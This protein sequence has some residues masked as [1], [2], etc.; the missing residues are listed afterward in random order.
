MI[1]LIDIAAPALLVGLLIAIVHVP[2][3]V[4]VIKR[5][6]IFI[7]LAIAQIAALGFLSAEIILEDAHPFIHGLSAFVA[8]IIGGIVFKFIEKHQ[9]NLQEAWI[10]VFF[11]ASASLS[12]L[13]LSDQPHGAE[14]LNHLLSG[15]VLFT[16]Y[17]DFLL[18][19][20]VY[21]ILFV[22]ATQINRAMQGLSFYVLFA[23]T[24][25]LSVQIVG[26][27]VVFASLIIPALIFT[28]VTN[29]KF[30]YVFTIIS[31][32]VGITGSTLLDVPAGPS[33]VLTYFAMALIATAAIRRGTR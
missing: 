9:P 25:T 10:G 33:L 28:Q 15:Q 16:T 29:N 17:Q 26:V 21:L 8:A 13:I 11:V 6:I 23:L 22:I 27:Y 5:G 3:G 19:L 18:Y 12:V 7:D 30:P 20:P 24:I 32:V 31:I 4:E 2:F 14:E 1:E